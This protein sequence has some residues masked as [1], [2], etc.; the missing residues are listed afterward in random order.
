M[1]DPNSKSAL[2]ALGRGL[3]ILDQLIRNEGPVRYNELRASLPGVQ[4]STLSRILKALETYGYIDRDPD[5][6]YSTTVK[7]S[8]WSPYLRATTSDLSTLA[9]KEIDQLV[10]LGEESAAVVQLVDDRILTLC[11]RTMKDG[12]QVLSAGDPLHFEA[13]HAG[14]IAILEQLNQSERKSCIKDSASELIVTKSLQQIID[15]MRTDDDVLIDRSHARPGICRM[16]ISFKHGSVLGAVFF[17]LTV[18]ACQSKGA[19]LATLLRASV[20][21]LKA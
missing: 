5:N 9:H 19:H 18:E 13:D 11:S 1:P 21:R 10:A 8:A 3:Y 4:D 15:S 16:A 7:V 20:N 17:C 12:I 6:G 2:P 14:A